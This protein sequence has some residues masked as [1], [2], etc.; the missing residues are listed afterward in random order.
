M[1]WAKNVFLVWQMLWCNYYWPAFSFSLKLGLYSLL[2][3]H[4]WNRN[5]CSQ[6]QGAFHWFVR[7]FLKQR[8]RNYFC[9]GN[10][11]SRVGRSIAKSGLDVILYPDE[12]LY[13]SIVVPCRH[14][15]RF[16]NNFLHRKQKRSQCAVTKRSL[17]YNVDP[18]RWKD[19]F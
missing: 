6:D 10:F 14:L 7:A 5:W 8:I 2:S 3:A 12:E 9:K 17:P 18:M 16:S 19:I 15:K 1:F 11:T 4:W 13:S